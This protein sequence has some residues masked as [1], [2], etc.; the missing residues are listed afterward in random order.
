MNEESKIQKKIM[1]FL[2]GKGFHVIR[3]ISPTKSGEADL[4]ACAPDGKFWAI[5]VK[6]E[7]GKT[8]K[9]QEVKLEEIRK[10]GG[11]AF[12]AYGMENFK[13]NY[14]LEQNCHE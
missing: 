13:H 1:D 5:E 12:V 3:N 9:L 10:R 2:E 11:I 8:S 6:T 4:V 14:H 7:K